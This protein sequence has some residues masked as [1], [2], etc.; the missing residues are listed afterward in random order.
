MST[1]SGCPRTSS[2]TST[3]T[4]TLNF[5]LEVN[6][7]SV[8]EDPPPP[9]P[10]DDQHDE[11]ADDLADDLP[12]EVPEEDDDDNDL[13]FECHICHR[14]FKQWGGLSTHKRRSHNLISP[15][16]LR[17]K[18][19]QCTICKSY[20]GTRRH[21][22]EHLNK[23]LYCAF[24]TIEEITPMTAEEYHRDVHTLQA[25]T[26]SLSRPMA[27]RTGPIRTID[28][29]PQS[30]QAPPINP[31]RNRPRQPQP[32]LAAQRTIAIDII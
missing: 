18:G 10:R 30:Q 3:T 14:R 6:E 7:P 2:P 22:I 23:R 31:M 16:V 28:G 8:L 5:R 21:L 19:T 1:S 29:V 24:N 25:T 4:T 12:P 27:P 32:P 9:P 20:L 13:P 11:R 17:V 26:T 15:L